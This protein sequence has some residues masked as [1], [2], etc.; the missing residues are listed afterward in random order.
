VNPGRILI[1]DDEPSLLGVMEQYLRR[2][3]YEVTACRSGQQAWKLF[4]S[5]PESYALVLA[6]IV[7][8]NLSGEQLLNR[9][10]ELNPRICILVCSGYP[11]DPSS[12]PVPPERVG[13]L[14]K[15]FAPRML[16]EM[17]QRLLERRSEPP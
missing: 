11:F 14:Q 8:P 2:L 12:L 3:K 7:M 6:D 5:D 13:F 4:E 10:L 16:V 9:M 1:V 15:P 17:V